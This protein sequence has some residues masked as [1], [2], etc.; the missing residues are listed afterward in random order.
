LL[1]SNS[2][3]AELVHDS[4][5]RGC[6]FNALDDKNLAEIIMHAT[7]EGEQRNQREQVIKWNIFFCRKVGLIMFIRDIWLLKACDGSLQH[8]WVRRDCPAAPGE[9]MQALK[10]AGCGASSKY[11]LILLEPVLCDP[12]FLKA[13]YFVVSSPLFSHMSSSCYLGI[14]SFIHLWQL[15]LLIR[16]TC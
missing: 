3:W 16:L 15:E 6:F 13:N 14:M 9:A 2:I 5:R 7:K 12:N 11:F 1:A 10:C 4:K 8:I